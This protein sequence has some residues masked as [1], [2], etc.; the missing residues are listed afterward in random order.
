M[1]NAKNW[2]ELGVWKSFPD[3]RVKQLESHYGLNLIRNDINSD[4]GAELVCDATALELAN[5]SVCYVGS[6][7][8]L[9]HISQP[10]FGP[11]REF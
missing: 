8:V 1:E 7:S 11:Q 6:N 3:S 2:L 10:D 4:Y 9:E 5:N